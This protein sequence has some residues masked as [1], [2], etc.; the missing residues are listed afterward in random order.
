[1]PMGRWV[2]L[3]V[4]MLVALLLFLPMRLALGALDLGANGVTARQVGGSVWSGRLGELTVG[5]VPL[6]TVD[7]ALSPVSLLAGRARLDLAR[8][9]G[10]PDD[11]AGA[12]TVS[13]NMIGMDDVTAAVSVA[14]LF[15]PLPVTALELDDVSA[16]FVAGSCNDAGGRV[17]ARLAGGIAGLAL[18]E[19]LTGAP[20]CAGRDLLVPLVSQSGLVR[21]ALRVSATGTYTADVGVQGA[22]AVTGAALRTLGFAATDGGY[23]LRTTGALGG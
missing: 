8:H 9:R 20:T 16:H 19:G 23:R 18:Q 7:A 4:A 3:L 14:Q 15:Q 6:G 12:I 10:A 5:G 11:L 17:R 22:D 2:L 21:V 13:R 1:M